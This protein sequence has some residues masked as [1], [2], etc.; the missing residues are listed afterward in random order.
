[1]QRLDSP[2][3]RRSQN[4]EMLGVAGMAWQPE[5]NYVELKIQSLQ[6]GK[7]VRGR[8]SS[9]TEIFTGYKG[10]FMDMDKFV[11][12]TLNKGQGTSCLFRRLR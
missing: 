4:T 6:F 3:A 8:L 10:S 7:V 11:P 12:H 5:A 2:F 9:K 1:M